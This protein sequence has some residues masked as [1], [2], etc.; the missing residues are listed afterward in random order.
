VLA[1]GYDAERG[2]GTF[3]M[4]EYLGETRSLESKERCVRDSLGL[5]SP[6]SVKNPFLVGEGSGVVR[7]NVPDWALELFRDDETLNLEKRLDIFCCFHERFFLNCVTFCFP[8]PKW[9]VWKDQPGQRKES[10]INE[11]KEV[12]LKRQS[13]SHL[14]RRVSL[15]LI[16]RREQLF[17]R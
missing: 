1:D 8:D 9:A 12:G 11:S 5:M 2:L 3:E 4:L 15:L 13:V 16:G 14:G 7:D 10:G 6:G 17:D